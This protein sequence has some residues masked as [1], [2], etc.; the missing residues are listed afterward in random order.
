MEPATVG[1]RLNVSQSVPEPNEWRDTVSGE[2]QNFLEDAAN[3]ATVETGSVAR[4]ATAAAEAQQERLLQDMHD[5]GREIDRV[6][7]EPVRMTDEDIAAEL[8]LF[9]QP[10][11]LVL[12][13]ARAIE[14]T[15][16]RKNGF[17]TDGGDAT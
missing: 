13:I 15:T 5:A 12:K 2:P 1:L 11:N 9:P 8:N 7:A 6:I 17:P 14:T 4:A 10:N 3:T 16:L